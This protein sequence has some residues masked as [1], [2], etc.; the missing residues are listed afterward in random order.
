MNNKEFDNV[1]VRDGVVCSSCIVRGEITVGNGVVLRAPVSEKY[2]LT[3][4]ADGGIIGQVL[5]TNGSGVCSW[6][7]YATTVTDLVSSN[8][9]TISLRAPGALPASYIF[10][11]PPNDGT[12]GQLLT[13][14]GTGVAR[15]SDYST[16]DLDLLST[17]SNAV[18]LKAPDA[19]AASYTLTLPPNDGTPGQ[20]LTT[21]GTGVVSWATTSWTYTT[22]AA[23]IAADT[24]GA[25]NGTI[26]N[27]A[28]L[29]YYKSTGVTAIADKPDWLPFTDVYVDHFG[30]TTVSSRVSANASSV[31]NAPYIQAAIDYVSSTFSGGIVRFKYK[32][33]R[34][35][36]TITVSGANVHLL[37]VGASQSVLF[38]DFVGSPV[39]LIANND[40]RVE[41]LQIDAS[42]TR[43]DTNTPA[44]CYGIMY[45]T[46]ETTAFRTKN[47]YLV[48]V[49]IR[50]Q[51]SHALYLNT[52]GFTGTVSRCWF[53]GNKGHGV[54]IDNNYDNSNGTAVAVDV[55]G[56]CTIE[57][58]QVT[59][60]GGHGFSLGNVNNTV[61][62]T[63]ATRVTIR[64][65]EIGN[66]G[67]NVMYAAVPAQIFMWGCTDSIVYANV[68]KDSDLTDAAIGV[69]VVGRNIN[70]LNN[71][72]IALSVPVIV[73]SRVILPTTNIFMTGI[74]YLTNTASV[75]EAVR[76]QNTS[77]DVESEPHGIYV[78]QYNFIGGIT[79]AVKTGTGMDAGEGAWRVAGLGLPGRTLTFRKTADQSVTSSTTLVDDVA[80][81]F[82]MAANEVVTFTMVLAVTA[83]TAAGIKMQ[84]AVTN[85]IVVLVGLP[86][87]TQNAVTAGVNIVLTGTSTTRMYTL[88]GSATAGSS[89]GKVYLRW[90]QNTSDTTPTIV[91]GSTSY[92]TVVRSTI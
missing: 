29:L 41:R 12:P 25:A 58:C 82:Q 79:T 46:D 81:K 45:Y 50:S 11:L 24:T 43:R 18:T 37:G 40:T 64:N 32:Y 9:N 7:D 23:F 5:A 80:V 87:S 39:L 91:H 67:T 19:L 66:N 59:S 71:R 1:V 73:D 56:L 88:V 30:A 62:S 17:N 16:P 38:A 33:Y 70:L 22:R 13:T 42:D 84:V 61:S 3:L 14:D 78:S 57:E 53:V 72:Y 27:A 74:N 6:A 34:T 10:T 51:P 20:L 2:I 21:D 60:N 76:V 36:T 35:T 44:R 15:W 4:P 26:V 55:S 47:S 69:V 28:G 92:V 31:N 77:G 68:L 48:S 63:Q 65:C 54:L 86:N 83:S 75:R 52:T 89:S 8:A 90:A 49:T 85:S